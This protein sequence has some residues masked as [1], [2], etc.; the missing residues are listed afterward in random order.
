MRIGEKI[1]NIRTAKDM[2]QKQLAG[3]KITRN[4]LSRIESGA[5]TPSLDTLLYIAGRLNVS[6]G[7]LLAEG[8]DELMYRKMYLIE[9]I[10]RAFR[11][12]ELEICRDLC[13]SS[14]LEGDDEINLILARCCAGLAKEKFSAGKIRQAARLFE[15]AAEY[16]GRSAY[17]SGTILAEAGIYLRYMRRISQTLGGE[18]PGQMVSD[19]L[20]FGDPFCVYV[21]LLERLMEGAELSGLKNP[22]YEDTQ[23][24]YSAHIK[25]KAA[26]REGRHHEARELLLEI[27]NSRSAAPKPFYYNVF[28][29]LELC[30]K[31]IGD[32]RGAYEYAAGKLNLLEKMFSEAEV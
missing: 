14:G 15:E 20:A 8:E 19:G 2:T 13:L 24:P 18:L 4:M 29:D 27:L 32:Y 16:A 11:G 9:N 10:R 30:S 6:P 7:Y 26:V 22:G 17:E 23:N 31:E 12:G 5:A 28:Y 1:K 3:E 25:S 21:V